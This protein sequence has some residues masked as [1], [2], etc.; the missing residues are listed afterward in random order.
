MRSA[1]LYLKKMET[2]FGGGG[3]GVWIVGFFHSSEDVLVDMWLTI[4]KEWKGK[5][6]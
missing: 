6:Q 3:R 4:G 2:I 5:G 1:T